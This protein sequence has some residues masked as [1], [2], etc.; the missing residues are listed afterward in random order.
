MPKDNILVTSASGLLG[1]N[2][3]QIT[4]DLVIRG[5]SSSG[6]SIRPCSPARS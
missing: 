3:V 2:A 6:P 1:S 4:A 5:R